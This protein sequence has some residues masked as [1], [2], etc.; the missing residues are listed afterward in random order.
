MYTVCIYRIDKPK[1]LYK[2]VKQEIL[3]LINNTYISKKAF[4][5]HYCYFK[6]PHCMDVIKKNFKEKKVIIASTDTI[7]G[8]IGPL[9]VWAFEQLMTIK[10]RD[11]KPFVVLVNSYLQLKALVD[12]DSYERVY[13]F[14]QRFWPGPLTCIATLNPLY[15]QWL[16]ELQKTVAIRMPLHHGLSQIIDECGPLFSTSVNI[17]GCPFAKTI[18][19]VS[20]LIMEKVFVAILDDSQIQEGLPSTIIDLTDQKPILVRQGLVN[21]D[22]VVKNK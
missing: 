8:L 13:D 22:D 6:D 7:L 11:L 4:F 20:P 14:V 17:S 12:H 15:K 5:M 19:D 9:E 2:N 3:N 21:V 16:F 18:H 1:R 10:K